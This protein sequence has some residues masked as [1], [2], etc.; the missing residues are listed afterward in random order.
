MFFMG[1]GGGMDPATMMV[2]MAVGSTLGRQLAGTMNNVMND[3]QANAFKPAPAVPP[4]PQNA[5]AA[6]VQVPNKENTMHIYDEKNFYSIDRLM[7]FGMSTSIAQQ[8]VNNMN[9]HMKNMFIP[10]AGNPMQP[11]QQGSNSPLS[12]QQ[13][14]EIEIIPE[15]VYYALI[16]GKQSGPYCETELA[17][18]IN[19]K[20][21]TKETYIWF[22][23]INEWTKAENVPT[24]LRLV[25]LVPP[26][27][28]NGV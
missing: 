24:I 28:P 8:M 6:P 10:G 27:L 3:M 2:G 23:G 4:A 9:H 14:S 17:R 15:P 22:T 7:E 16:D 25:A 20:K 13:M 19:E 12:P 11:S 26:P 21:L 18:L 1:G 5:P